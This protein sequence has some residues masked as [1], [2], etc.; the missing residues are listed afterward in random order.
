MNTFMRPSRCLEL[1]VWVGLTNVKSVLKAK[2]FGGL[3][4]YYRS[5]KLFYKQ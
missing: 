2:T 3:K 5:A 4:P 1:N